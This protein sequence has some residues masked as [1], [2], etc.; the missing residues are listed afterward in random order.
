MNLSSLIKFLPKDLSWQSF[1][2]HDARLGKISVII[3]SFTK[4]FSSFE[5]TNISFYLW[6]HIYQAFTN[7]SFDL[8]PFWHFTII[9]V[10]SS[11]AVV[12]FPILSF[13][14]NPP[15][16]VC[17]YNL[18]I[19]APT[20]IFHFIKLDD[21]IEL[22]AP[23]F[24]HSY[25]IFYSPRIS[26][27]ARPSWNYRQVAENKKTN[28]A[29]RV[30]RICNFSC[31]HKNQNPIHNQTARGQQ[32]RKRIYS[33]Y[34]GNNYWQCEKLIQPENLIYDTNTLSYHT[35]YFFVAVVSIN[36]K[37]WVAVVEN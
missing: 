34:A 16:R 37:S 9:Q 33:F 5:N 20:H 24:D 19:I 10:S 27:T 4:L 13:C 6:I 14:H 7:A 1:L 35:P 18:I 30:D 15:G 23:P 22:Q 28:D 26:A 25:I 31:V 3:A 11:L 2:W 12:A 32:R 17:P 29:N 36:L 21:R 8:L